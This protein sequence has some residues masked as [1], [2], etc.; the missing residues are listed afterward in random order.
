MSHGGVGRLTWGAVA[1]RVALRCHA[2]IQAGVDQQPESPA[3]EGGQR[4]AELVPGEEPP[5][6]DHVVWAVDDGVGI[7]SETAGHLEVEVGAGRSGT[8]TRV[9]DGAS[10]VD[11]DGFWR[12][13]WVAV[14]DV[15]RSDGT[16]PT[17]W[18][19]IPT[20][21]TT[22]RPGRAPAGRTCPECGSWVTAESLH[23]R[24]HARFIPNPGMDRHLRPVP[25]PRRRARRAAPQMG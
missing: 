8:V 6:N 12:P 19:E 11:I 4:R 9:V 16:P 7:M 21:T 10:A 13:R 15:V 24:W 3:L 14:A 5:V 23:G 17:G 20:P 2:Q 1:L 22:T 25:D 18:S